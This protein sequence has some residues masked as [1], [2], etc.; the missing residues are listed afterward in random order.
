[1]GPP[2]GSPFRVL[3]W[4]EHGSY[5]DSLAQTGHIFYLPVPDEPRPGHAGRWREWGSNVIEV[6]ES[7]VPDVDVDL[8][9]FQSRATWEVDRGTVLSR[10]QQRLPRIYLEHD[11]PREQPTDQ[12]H[13]VDDPGTL[14]V[15]VTAFNDLMW[16]A[17]RTPTRVIDHGIAAPPGVRWTGD[18]ERGLVVVNDL[19]TRGRR[20]GLD[21]FEAARK[22]VPIDLVGMHATDV[23]GLGEIRR[24]DLPAFEARFRFFFH[25]VR[26]T[27]LAMALIEAM[28]IGMPIVALATTELPTVLIDGESGIVSTDPARLL[29]GMRALLRDRDLGRRLGERARDIAL[30]RFSIERFTRDWTDAFATVTGR[31][32]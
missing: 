28:T 16:D 27:S 29:D 13:W 20:L 17:G 7:N 32:R 8:V 9:L 19:G 23:G 6:P 26:W 1:M 12:R 18:L 15:H 22:E 31:A 14:L 3:T 24:S 4:H 2:G 25:P 5:L 11:P 21:I 10:E 30:E